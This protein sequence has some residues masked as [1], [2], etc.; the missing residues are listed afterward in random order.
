MQ[1]AQVNW[2]SELNF[3]IFVQTNRE[4]LGR[5]LQRPTPSVVQKPCAARN[6][7]NLNFA[8]IAL[9]RLCC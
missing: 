6:S 5:V 8:L 1:D 2:R 4:Q 9:S 7:L 3:V